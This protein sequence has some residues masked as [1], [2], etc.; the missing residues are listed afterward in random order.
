MQRS[1]NQTVNFARVCAFP[2]R[3]AAFS[4]GRNSEL[5][6]NKKYN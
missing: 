5:D 2:F 1:N 4:L 3:T 6:S